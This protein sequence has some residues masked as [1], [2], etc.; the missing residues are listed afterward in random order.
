MIRKT[1]LIFTFLGVVIFSYSQISL[2]YSGQL[3][4]LLNILQNKYNFKFLYSNNDIND[5][6]QISVNFN[7]STIEDI[8]L[9]ISK[10]LNISY[11]IINKQIVL[12]PAKN[13]KEKIVNQNKKQ[14]TELATKKDSKP[15]IRSSIITN[16][17]SIYL[18]N[19]INENNIE[20]KIN[21][22]IDSLNTLSNTQNTIERNHLNEEINLNVEDRNIEINYLQNFS[23]KDNL[24]KK[25]EFVEDL[26]NEKISINLFSEQEYS[27]SIILKTNNKDVLDTIQNEDLKNTIVLK[28]PICEFAILNNFLCDIVFIPNLGVECLIKKK[29]TIAL[30][31]LWTHINWGDGSKTYRTFIFCPEIKYYL[32]KFNSFYI[33]TM[34]NIGQFNF[35]LSD[36]GKQ[37]DLIGAGITGG[38][39]F[40]LNNYLALDFGL[41]L[42]Y[43]NFKYESYN[44]INKM[45]I[46]QGKGTKH[47]WGPTKVAISLKIKI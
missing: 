36:M 38:Y 14:S 9:Q 34:F 18:A 25:T 13:V 41:G 17:D 31:V 7:N 20:K 1:I 16:T 39:V 45:N 46:R 23:E 6:A 32:S 11:R 44:Y 21:T 3:K 8:M 28:E 37:G 47:L 19:S 10:Q 27:D 29:Y 33:G 42:G 22:N 24:I 5:N 26:S 2:Q 43:T 30:N 35:K 15:I 4:G 40:K 12:I